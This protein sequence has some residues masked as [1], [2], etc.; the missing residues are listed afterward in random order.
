MDFFTVSQTP[1]VFMKNNKQFFN[2]HVD[3]LDRSTSLKMFRR[4][5]SERTVIPVFKCRED[6]TRFQQST[7]QSC[8]AFD[9]WKTEEVYP[10]DVNMSHL[11]LTSKIH[12]IPK[13]LCELYD[14]APFDLNDA[15]TILSLSLKAHIGFFVIGTFNVLANTVSMNG[16]VVDLTLYDHFTD[17]EHMTLL[18]ATYESIYLTSPTTTT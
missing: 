11:A 1:Y 7:V 8:Y 12:H 17:Q 14:V 5:N 6:A 4:D 9:T 18:R 13:Y 2:V 15:D 16:I 3:N 10:I